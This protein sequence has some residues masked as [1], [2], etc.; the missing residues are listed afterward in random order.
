M[1]NM[2]CVAISFAVGVVAGAFGVNYLSKKRLKKRA[3]NVQVDPSLV[4][5]I[6]ELYRELYG[7]D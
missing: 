2:L 3:T 1:K 4:D 5:D 7:I 6:R